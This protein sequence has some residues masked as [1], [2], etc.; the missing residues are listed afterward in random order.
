MSFS[1]IFLTHDGYA[2][3]TARV[4]CY[5][6]AEELATRG[7][8]TEVLSLKDHLGAP[9]DGAR[10]YEITL[11][12]KVRLIF[13]ATARLWKKRGSLIYVQKASYHAYAALLLHVLGRN[14]LILDYDDWD[15][16]AH[17]FSPAL[18]HI[19]L[20]HAKHLARRLALRAECVVVSSGELV[21]YMQRWNSRLHLIP[22][23]V[24]TARFAFAVPPRES[25][26]VSF[27]WG[28]VV[29]GRRVLDDLR[30]A[31]Q[32]F[33]MMARSRPERV[34]FVVAGSGA[35]MP[36]VCD[37]L[38]AMQREGLQTKWLGSI[39]PDSVPA[40]LADVDVG[41]LP[42]GEEKFNRFK[43]PTKLF[44]MMSVGRPVV[45]SAVGEACTVVE[46]GVT[47]FLAANVEDMAQAMEKLALDAEL[48]STMGM[49]AR[50]RVEK[51]YSMKVLGD[52]LEKI[53]R[54]ILDKIPADAS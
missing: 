20:F 29:W 36:A 8:P 4:R 45:A 18:R 53:V 24:D 32:A 15:A 27:F 35:F 48:R 13:S 37:E 39:A 52:A 54:P 11:L 9:H 3:P 47:G 46:H 49:A 51:H 16:P 1:V 44:E 2:L 26:V 7:I 5:R 42:L 38:R 22:T 40:V 33:R 41:M 10:H 31:I 12:E 25:S 50:I 43:S 17:P 21:K 14:Q 30:L 34:R 19:N 28:G 6:F 23:G